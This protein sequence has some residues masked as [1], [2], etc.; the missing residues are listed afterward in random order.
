LLE[1]T[2]SSTSRLTQPSH[3]AAIS[4]NE[5]TE[6]AEPRDLARLEVTIEFAYVVARAD[7]RIARKEKEI[8]EQYIRNQFGNDPALLNRTRAFCAH[9]ESAAIDVEKS[10]QWITNL[11]TEDERR[12]LLEF[13]GEIADAAGPRNQREVEFLEKVSSK[14]GIRTAPQQATKPQNLSERRPETAHSSPEPVSDQPEAISASLI[15]EAKPGGPATLAERLAVL[16]IDAAV[17]LSAELVRRQFN[18]LSQRYAPDKFAAMGSEFV[19]VAENKRAALLAAASALLEQWGETL[20]TVSSPSQPP[21][22]RHNPDMDAI[23]G[24]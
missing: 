6:L 7:G 4:N 17:P 9:Y 1:K 2:S 18:L 22:L 10:L 23:L 11:F 16:E 14:L 5:I 19:A 12:Q 13:A 8:I 20:E 24:A 15:R 3:T 21:E